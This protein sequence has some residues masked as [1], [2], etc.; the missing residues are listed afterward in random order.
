MLDTSG[1]HSLTRSSTVAMTRL[2]MKDQAVT[3]IEPVS[4]VKERQPDMPSGIW[5]RCLPL[6]PPP[7]LNNQDT[8]LGVQPYGN[9][10]TGC[11]R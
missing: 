5:G 11:R 8:A 4:S 7:K 2:Q 10:N 6:G 1:I 9:Q 3:L